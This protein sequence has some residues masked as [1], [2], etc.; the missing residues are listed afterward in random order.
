[1]VYNIK[2]YSC[3]LDTPGKKEQELAIVS[4]IMDLLN[5]NK[6]ENLEEFISK[7]NSYQD[8]LKNNRMENV[9]KHFGNSLNEENFTNILN[10]L[11]SLT[12]NKKRFQEENIKTTNI[13][14]KQFNSLETSE[15]TYFLD[16]S[17][18]KKTIEEQMKDLQPTQEQFQT[19]DIKKNTEN[20]FK[21]LEETKKES[22]RLSKINEINFDELNNIEKQLY[23]VAKNYQM[24]SGKEIR[25]DLNKAIMVD[26]TNTIMQIENRNG[27]YI[28]ELDGNEI[29]KDNM[30][31]VDKKSYQKTL[32]MNP[33]TIYS[34]N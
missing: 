16:N 18:S 11:R 32:T 15:H 13:N 24:S 29:E 30:E 6:Y 2:E 33:N 4:K 8:F 7:T 28:I 10:N 21:E 22:I 3:N 14:D 12:N 25:I 23:Q 31:I 1:M 19:S 17:N 20:M 26:D 27:E 5:N 9:V 34:N